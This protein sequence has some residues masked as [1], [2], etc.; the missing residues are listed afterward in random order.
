MFPVRVYLRGAAHMESRLGYFLFNDETDSGIIALYENQSLDSLID[1][2][3]EE[4]AHAR[5][6][7]LEDTEDHSED[8]DHHGTFWGE[9]GR[10]QKAAR[11]KPWY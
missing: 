4:Y 1:S 10:L 5:C 6:H 9:Y 8:P 2:F 11:E 7:H 3:L